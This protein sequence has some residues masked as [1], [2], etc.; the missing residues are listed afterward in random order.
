MIKLKIRRQDG[1]KAWYDLFEVEDRPGMNL[2]EAL[3]YVQEKLDGSL[4]FRY[5]CRGAVCGSC[6]ML[7]NRVPRLACKVQV[8]DLRTEPTNEGDPEV[9]IANKKTETDN[10]EILIEPLPNLEV[11]RDLVVDMDPFYSLLKNVRPWLELKDDVPEKE[12]IMDQEVQVKL[13]QYTNC[14][15][16]AIC[17]GSCPVAAR[18]RQYYG[19]AALAKAWRFDLDPREN[20]RNREERL[21]IVDSRSGVWG[22]DTVYKCVAV[23]PKK[24]APT[25][26]INELRN[27]IDIDR[28]KK[29]EE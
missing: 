18:D 14:I 3:F 26:G 11:I 12:N 9:L 17:H 2:L 16:C 7:V 23:C 4:T 20:E 19:P 5:S 15:L 10:D 1:E 6:G 8:S 27:R 13:E 28:K 29:S 24:V 22:C 25:L 21:E